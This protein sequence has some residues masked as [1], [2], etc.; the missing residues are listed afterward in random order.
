MSLTRFLWAIYAWLVFLFG[1]FFAVIFAIFVP[2]LERRRRWVTAVGRFF[3]QA[4]G[5]PSSVHGLHHLPE[6]HSIVVANHTSYLDG[7]I[8]QSF[9]P[10]RF[11]Y[12]IKAEMQKIPVAHFFLRR[13]GSKFVERFVASGSARD[14]RVLLKAAS[15][16]ESLAFFPEGTFVSEVGLGR[17]RLGAFAA[18]IK[19]SLPVVPVV[20]R[21][22]RAI[23][24]SGRILPRRAALEVDILDVI[25][26][27]DEAYGSAALLAEAAR[28]SILRRLDEP[29]L[30]IADEP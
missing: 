24:P 7:V 22:S 9:L 11:S 4:A 30:I 18:A 13:I 3:F 15:A 29:D 26:P 19:G 28:Q 17:F 25:S 16:G 23:L 6:G 27:D 8:L 20:I 14:A 21:G 2:G 12:V 1:L 10:P 5:I